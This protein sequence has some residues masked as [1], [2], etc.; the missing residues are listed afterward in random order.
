MVVG[1]ER[2]GGAGP[3]PR[4]EPSVGRRV[5]NKLPREARAVHS[6]PFTPRAHRLHARDALGLAAKVRSSGRG[7]STA[8]GPAGPALEPLARAQL[9]PQR[10]QPRRRG[11]ESMY[12]YVV[13]VSRRSS[14]ARLCL[15]LLEVLLPER[16]RVGRLALVVRHPLGLV[17]QG[18][19]SVSVRSI[20]CSASPET[21]STAAQG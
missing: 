4:A 10:A 14:E 13:A 7:T 15:D 8:L 11:R 3:W 9:R 1:G 18:K 17:L 19:E 2:G 20:R 5:A 16:V 21:G 12:R 6:R